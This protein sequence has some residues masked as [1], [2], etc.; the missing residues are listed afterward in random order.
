MEQPQSPDGSSRFADPPRDVQVTIIRGPDR[1]AGRG[2]LLALPPR[3]VIALVLLLAAVAAVLSTT[4]GG[5][6]NPAQGAVTGQA[7]M[8]GAV[9][10]PAIAAVYRYP[11]GCLGASLSG[12]AG[13]P[14]SSVDRAGPCWRYGV[15]LTAILHRVH[16]G[17]QL[18]LE[19]VSARCPRLSLPAALRLQLVSCR[20]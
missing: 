8:H 10:P 16:R 20:R 9:G 15:F 17:W 4:R 7:G 13:A 14:A 3:A 18:G 6:A 5:R 11:L 12:G 2:G 19:V 1:R